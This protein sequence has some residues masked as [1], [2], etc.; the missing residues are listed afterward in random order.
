M[1]NASATNDLSKRTSTT[2]NTTV[3]TI[4]RKVSFGPD[5]G[6]AFAFGA[7][8]VALPSCVVNLS[9]AGWRTG[10]GDVEGERRLAFGS[11][12]KHLG[13]E[14]QH[15]PGSFDLPEDSPLEVER[16]LNNLR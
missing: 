16:L 5:A 13:R 6:A 8:L 3:S 7:V 12:M 11:A 15:A 4:S 1:T 14:I 9:L 10:A 2:T